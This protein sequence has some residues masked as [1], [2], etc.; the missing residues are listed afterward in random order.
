MPDKIEIGQRIQ[1]SDGQNSNPVRGRLE[2]IQVAKTAFEQ[3]ARMLNQAQRDLWNDFYDIFPEL[4]DF[5]IRLEETDS[6]LVAV[7]TGLRR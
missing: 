3:S 7:V 5:E 1:I 6:K 2:C 4:K